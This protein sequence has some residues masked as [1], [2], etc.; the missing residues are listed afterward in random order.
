[1]KTDTKQ[2]GLKRKQNRE[3][4]QLKINK[5]NCMKNKPK[6]TLKS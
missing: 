2:N 3:E 5:K 4:Q 1:M 6:K